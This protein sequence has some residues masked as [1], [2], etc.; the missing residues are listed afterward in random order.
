[1]RLLRR[2]V[3]QTLLYYDLWE[4]PLTI[5]E[6]HAFLPVRVE[7]FPSFTRT[8]EDLAAAGDIGADRGYYFVPG[9]SAAVV[10]R[11]IAGH[12]RARSMWRWARVSTHVIKRCPFVRG[13]YVSGDLSKNVS[14]P[15]GDVD[16][17]VITV[18]GRLWITRSLLIM[19]KKTFLLNRKKFFCLNLF[20]AANGLRV[21]EQNIYQ[22]TEIA[23]LKALYNEEM[24]EAYLEAN[25]WITD[26]FPNFDASLLNAPPANNRHSIFQRLTERVL[27][28]FP[29]DRIDSSL[30]RMMESVW[31]TRYPQFD[32]ETRASIFRSTKTESRAYAGNV[33]G[34]ILNRYE[35]ALRSYGVLD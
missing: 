4:Y 30:L 15:G 34:A 21:D 16:F 32:A 8:V 6:L 1:M 31:A 24:F 12:R 5:R 35:N 7:S 13:V 27:E 14:G 29:L 11:R 25:G 23:Q 22:A 19:F 20:T 10:D 33:Q 9:R 17:F 3:L 26:F 2:E 18:P 28:L